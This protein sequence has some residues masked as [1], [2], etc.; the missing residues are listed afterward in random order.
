MGLKGI[1]NMYD[2]FKD[3]DF[4]DRGQSTCSDI[5]NDIQEKVREANIPCQFFLVGSGA[6]NMVTQNGDG[7][8]DFDYNLNVLNGFNYN[9]KRLKECC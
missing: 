2:Y 1:D 7:P 8:I 3:K 6:R 5:M 4:L 9:E